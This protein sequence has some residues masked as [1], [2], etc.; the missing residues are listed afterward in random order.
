[1]SKKDLGSLKFHDSALL[2]FRFEQYN[3]LTS[4]LV[5]VK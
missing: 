5:W 1:M 2:L 4:I 3:N